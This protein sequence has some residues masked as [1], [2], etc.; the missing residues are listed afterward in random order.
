MREDKALNA[1]LDRLHAAG[2]GF[3][4]SRAPIAELAAAVARQEML[5]EQFKSDNALLQ[6][7]LAYFGLFSVKLGASNLNGPIFPAVSE[8]A[9][10]MLHLTLDTSPPAAQAVAARLDGLATQSFPRK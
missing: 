1:A 4:E 8:L 6:N 2:A 3:S 5:T 10:A 9:A 7:S